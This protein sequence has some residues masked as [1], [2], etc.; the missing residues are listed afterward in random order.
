VVELRIESITDPLVGTP[1]SLPLV[2]Q[3][4]ARA[5]TMGF[6]SARDSGSIELSGSFL[7]HL[8]E[9]VRREGIAALPTA[10]LLEVLRRDELDDD[11]LLDALR[12]TIAALDASPIPEREWTPARELLGDE[13]LAAL[14]GVSESSLRRYATGERK[15]PDDVA[16]RLHVVA[17]LLASLVGSFNEYGVRRWFQRPRSAL[18]GA[19]PGEVLEH[20][21]NEGDERLQRVLVLADELLGAANAT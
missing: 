6:L 14:T 4:V 2:L 5:Q 12:A 15:T 7:A 3:L 18:D 17:R 1:R 19:T 20:A 11:E 13:L 8:A 10:R 16:W 21:E 9:R